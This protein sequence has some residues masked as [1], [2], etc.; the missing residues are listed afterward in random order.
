MSELNALYHRIKDQIDGRLLEFKNLFEKGSD[1]DL[2][3][4]MCF[5]MCTPQNNAQKAWGA[6]CWLSYAGLLDTGSI[7]D[8][9]AIL[10]TQGTRFHQN[11][12]EYIVKNRHAFYPGT[13]AKISRILREYTVPQARDR[14]ATI[15][16]GWGLK[17]ASHFLR[18]IGFGS[19]IC[20]LDRHILRQLSLRGVID[21]ITLSPR[22]YHEIEQEMIRFAEQE[23]IPVDALDLVLWYE[24]KGEL[25]K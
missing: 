20:I 19:H 12:A 5:C 7:E 16:H 22:N 23:D 15:V 17:E 13:K 25:F 9:A 4:E 21:S 24:E 6:V 1:N 18:N 8:I 14:F 3:K 10:R 11:K 2:Y